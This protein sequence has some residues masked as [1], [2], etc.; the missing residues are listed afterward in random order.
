M[1]EFGYGQELMKL[2]EGIFVLFFSLIMKP[3]IMLFL[4]EDLNHETPVF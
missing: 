4:I 3:F 1:V 2:R